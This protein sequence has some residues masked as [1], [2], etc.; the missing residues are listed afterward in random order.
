MAQ[1]LLNAATTTGAGTGKVNNL[2]NIAAGPAATLLK[3]SSVGAASAA[4]KIS[5]NGTTY[6]IMLASTAS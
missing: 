1:I 3:T 2:F 4:L 6:Y 5:A